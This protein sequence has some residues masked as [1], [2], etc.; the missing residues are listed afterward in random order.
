MFR[1]MEG[2]TTYTLNVPSGKT[3]L[4]RSLAKEMGWVIEKPRRTVKRCG[5]D[6]ALDDIKAGRVHT[7]KNAED[8]FAK[9]GI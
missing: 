2:M 7:C 4:F 1:I 9:M 8:L 3:R 6:M 5:L